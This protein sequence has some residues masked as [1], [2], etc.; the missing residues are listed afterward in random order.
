MFQNISQKPF[1]IC[2]HYT[3]CGPAGKWVSLQSLWWNDMLWGKRAHGRGTQPAVRGWCVTEEAAP[4]LSLCQS[5]ECRHPV[6]V[7]ITF[8]W[9]LYT[10]SCFEVI[11]SPSCA[12][13]RSHHTPCICCHGNQALFTVKKNKIK[14]L[15]LHRKLDYASITYNSLYIFRESKCLNVWFRK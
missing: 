12:H 10:C 13:R 2:L 5:D 3:L 6:N 7:S 9:W 15:C 14:P 1:N 11:H 4:V 8:Q